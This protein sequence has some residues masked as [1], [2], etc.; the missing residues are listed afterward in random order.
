MGSS[1]IQSREWRHGPEGSRMVMKKD[2]PRIEDHAELWRK[3]LEDRRVIDN[4][5]WSAQ[6]LS[7]ADSA[8]SV[9]EN[10]YCTAGTDDDDFIDIE[11]CHGGRSAGWR[12]LGRRGLARVRERA[13]AR[14]EGTPE[15]ELPKLPAPG[16]LSDDEKEALAARLEQSGKER[17]RETMAALSMDELLVLA[18]VV[19]TNKTL[20]ALLAPMSLEIT[21][22]QHP[23]GEGGEGARLDALKGKTMSIEVAR[24]LAELCR[25]TCSDGHSVMVAAQRGF[26][27]DGVT[28]VVRRQPLRDDADSMQRVEYGVQAGTPGMVAGSVSA[29]RKETLAEWPLVD[30]VPAA[31][32]PPTREAGI[33]DALLAAMAA[34]LDREYER[35][36]A[37]SVEDFW[38]SVGKALQSREQVCTPMAIRF[39]ADEEKREDE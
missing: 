16:D 19:G 17:I 27:L 24:N 35:L 12:T 39:R 20:N 2:S 32:A 7:V 15:A 1:L 6:I 5:G 26:V 9:I 8:A 30:P 14:L 25:K 13:A 34:E 33:E 10:G 21:A 36:A 28:L 31:A 29:R 11:S 22:V 18:E 37:K 4:K 38:S 23:F 3:L